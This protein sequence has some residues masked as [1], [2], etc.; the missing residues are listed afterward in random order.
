ML[1]FFV[2]YKKVNIKNI[3]SFLLKKHKLKRLLEVNKTELN[4]LFVKCELTSFYDASKYRSFLRS[5]T[6]PPVVLKLVLTFFDGH[7][8]SFTHKFHHASVLHA[9]S[10]LVPRQ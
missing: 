4:S 9:K 6:V 1:Y 2:D 7:A 5:G 3:S 10:L 8:G